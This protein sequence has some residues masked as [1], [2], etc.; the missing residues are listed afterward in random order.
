MPCGLCTFPTEG[1]KL[2]DK[3]DDERIGEDM[4][5]DSIYIQIV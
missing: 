3:P 1:N 4:A 2:F 5:P